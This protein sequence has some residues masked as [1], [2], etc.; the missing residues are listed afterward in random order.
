[1]SGP[2]SSIPLA[3][4]G[5]AVRLFVVMSSG[6]LMSYGLRAINATIAPELVQDLGLSNTQLGSLTSAYFLSFA[7]MQLPVG[8]WLDRFGP[9]RVDAVLM[10]VA[11][12]GCL[13]FATA[14]GFAQ[15]W[16]GRALLG[17][18]FAAGLMACFAMFRLWFAPHQQTRLAAWTMTVG[19]CGVLTATLPVR[20][21]LSATDWRGVF[22][23]CAAILFGLSLLMWF[24]LPR[25]REPHGERSQS[26]FTLLTGYGEILGDGFF[27]RM[28][29]LGGLVQGGFIAIQ[30][31]WLGPWFIRVVGMT[32]QASASWLFA[33]NIALLLGFVAVGVLAPRVGPKKTTTV[34]V[35]GIAALLCTVLTGLAAAWPVVAGVWAWL[36]LA[37]CNTVFVPIHSRVGM[38][39]PGH[40]AGRALTA[41]NLLIFVA[42]FAVQSLLG[43]VVDWLL[44]AGWGETDAFRAGLAALV[45]TQSVVLLAFARWPALGKLSGLAKGPASGG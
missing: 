14:H 31:L 26:L 3:S 25:A 15:L 19:T 9:R 34:R 40:L 33:F 39:F 4:G 1:M 16:L 27:W 6:Y 22:L 42:A 44:S 11:G 18:G 20:A 21:L 13:V 36:A 28:A 29:L 24:A 38:S 35:A 10:A 17:V 45:V 43:V 32:P 37:V 12:S 7:L 23:V 8:I 41:Y 2:A 30:T 5:M